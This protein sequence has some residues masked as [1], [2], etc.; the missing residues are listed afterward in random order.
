MY[1]LGQ[2]ATTSDAEAVVSPRGGRARTASNVTGPVFYSVGPV[3][4]CLGTGSSRPGSGKLRRGKPG[5]P[6]RDYL[7]TRNRRM[8]TAPLGDKAAYL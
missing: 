7:R 6:R 5:K 8:V 2:T 3:G 4:S 1:Y